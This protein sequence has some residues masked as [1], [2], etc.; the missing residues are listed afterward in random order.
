MRRFH[1][2]S[3]T[4]K[5]PPWVC[6]N[7]CIP[8]VG[9]ILVGK[10]QKEY[11]KKSNPS[12]P[13]LRHPKGWRLK[14]PMFEEFLVTKCHQYVWMSYGWRWFSLLTKHADKSRAKCHN[15]S[16]VEWIPKNIDLNIATEHGHPSHL[17]AWIGKGS[18]LTYFVLF[19]LRMG[20]TTCSSIWS[21]RYFKP[22]IKI[23]PCQA[24]QAPD[25]PPSN[26][27]HHQM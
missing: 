24:C 1:G 25:I 22:A 23:S 21:F 9:A 10:N 5:I 15:L 7:I 2:I 6:L 19:T 18:S 16:S 17:T 8:P 20:K 3:L 14:V 4:N 26:P 12:N 27:V 11:D 13:I